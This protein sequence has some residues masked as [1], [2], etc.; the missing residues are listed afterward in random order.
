[1]RF[2]SLFFLAI[3]G[4]GSPPPPPIPSTP[5][6]EGV[7]LEL[8]LDDVENALAPLR[9]AVGE[10]N[11]AL[12]PSSAR[13]LTDA[14]VPLPSALRDVIDEGPVRAVAF[15]RGED[16]AFVVVAP[17][18]GELEGLASEG[19]LPGTRWVEGEAAAVYQHVLVVGEARRDVERAM[20]YLV[21]DASRR[22]VS[23]LSLETF[24]PAVPRALRTFVE[25]WIED[26]ARAARANIERERARHP[27]PPAMG[28]P[29]AVV[30][31]ALAVSRDALALLPDVEQAS[32]TLERTA[33]G[34]EITVRL[35]LRAGS[36]ASAA[37]SEASE[38]DLGALF[39]PLP[40]HTSVA[41]ATAASEGARAHRREA[42]VSRLASVGGARLGEGERAQLSA[43]LTAWDALRGDRSVMGI[44]E[45]EGRAMFF[46]ASDARPGEVTDLALPWASGPYARA[47]TEALVGCAPIDGPRPSLGV[48]DGSALVPICDDVAYAIARDA[49]W[50]TATIGRQTNGSPAGDLSRAFDGEGPALRDDADIARLARDRPAIAALLVFPDRLAASL[51]A[52][53]QPTPTP[54]GDAAVLVSLERAD[55]ALE[56]HVA[57]TGAALPA[58]A[59][60][61]GGD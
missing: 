15:E 49:P 4:C 43:L 25:T 45:T 16:F 58:L 61:I 31:S 26:Q 48:E 42:F 8:G 19:P 28:D 36:P 33:G 7:V 59:A 35:T 27:E 32:L 1:M 20:A 6:P 30:S 11:A 14:I 47:L 55:A 12:V 40:I 50:L 44:S 52:I 38:A 34:P 39:S 18:R 22:P 41:L 23:G 37:L 10:A 21:T 17:M 53:R 46:F 24:G 13:A 54:E 5:R 2:S 60:W 51:R 9:E 3:L 57:S 29:E 56:I